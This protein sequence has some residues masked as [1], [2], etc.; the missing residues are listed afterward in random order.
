MSKRN[1]LEIERAM[2]PDKDVFGRALF[3]WA[4]G[5]TMP[6]V[7]E[8][9]DGFTQI[10]AGPDVYLSDFKDWPT[11]E[12]QSVRYMRGRV[13][14]IGCGAGRV[15]LELQRRGVDAV[16]LDASPLAVRAAK[17]RGVNEVWSVPIQDLDARIETFDSLVL[18]GNNFGIFETPERARRLLARLAKGTKPGARLFAESTSAYFGGAPGF[19]RSYYRLNNARGRSPGQLK[20]RY[21]YGDLVGSWFRWLYVSRSEMRSILVG[22]GWHLDRVLG[23]HSSEPYVAILVK[24]SS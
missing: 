10:G 21:H 4:M 14:D 8:R 7:L 6:E 2:I 15:V 11:A 20:V 17:L 5:G 9:D 22:T 13:M 16:G 19:D 12:R 1:P 3:D 23:N 18:F 24:D